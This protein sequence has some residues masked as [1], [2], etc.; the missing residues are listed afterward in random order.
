MPVQGILVFIMYQQR[1]KGVHI[2]DQRMRLTSEVSQ[3]LGGN[4]IVAYLELQVLQG[5]RLL[6]YYAWENV[7]ARRIIGLR[8]REMRTIR[9]SSISAALL[10]AS[11]E[12][13]PV[14]ASILSFVTYSLTDHDLT[15]ATIFTSLQYLN[16]IREPLI[17]IPF[18]LH[19]YTDAAVALGRIQT[20][21]NAEELP[22]PYQISASSKNAVEVNGDFRWE[23]TAKELQARLDAQ[24]EG[25]SKTTGSTPSV[26]KDEPKDMPGQSEKVEAS[27]TA[28]TETKPKRGWFHRKEP[29]SPVLPVSSPIEE[30]KPSSTPVLD[31]VEQEDQPFALGGLTLTVPKG[32]FVAIVGRIGSGKSSLLQSMVGEMRKTR[33]TVQF[34]GSVAYVPQSAWIMNA[35]LRYAFSPTPSIL[36]LLSPPSHQRQ[37]PVRTR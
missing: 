6:K 10:V 17:L 5:I 14:L 13:V 37:Y 2:T 30:D 8:E 12:F 36:Y 16:V 4:T 7:Y 23:T 25:A 3:V 18:V 27:V 22:E 31:P 26:P 24:A 32:A 33:G 9:K 15:V 19:S 21:L 28:E 29:S 11:M 20:Y 34:G 1:Q 35:T